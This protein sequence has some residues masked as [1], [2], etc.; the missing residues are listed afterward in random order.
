MGPHKSHQSIAVWYYIITSKLEQEFWNETVS[1]TWF[2]KNTGLV[3]KWDVKGSRWGR[4]KEELGPG[5]QTAP[6]LSASRRWGVNPKIDGPP[7][8]RVRTPRPFRHSPDSSLQIIFSSLP[9]L[10]HSSRL[11]PVLFVLRFDMEQPN[12][13]HSERLSHS[14]APDK[15][16]CLKDGA[17]ASSGEVGSETHK[18]PSATQKSVHWS[19]ELVTEYPSPK[20][21]SPDG[22]NPYVD[23]S[24]AAPNPPQFNFKGRFF[25]S[26]N[27]S[28]LF[29]YW[30]NWDSK[31]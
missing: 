13:E 4:A 28:T 17:L 18:P 23:R 31:R 10:G 14:Q 2:R 12:G 26:L 22:S 29:L 25:F 27:I 20:I 1:I 16:Q 9:F 7:P 21:S 5:S 8:P 24:S 11:G 30:H 3:G 15:D 6:P 19:S